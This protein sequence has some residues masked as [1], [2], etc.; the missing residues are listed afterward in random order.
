MDDLILKSF[1][2]ELT[3]DEQKV[4]N[5]FLETEKGKSEFEKFLQIR[6]I[7]NENRLHFLDGFSEKVMTKVSV[8]DT[9]IIQYDFASALYK[10]FK[11][12]AIIGAAAIAILLA[13]IYYFHGN[14]GIETITGLAGFSSDQI[15][16]L[17]LYQ[18]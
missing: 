7:L 5:Q 1:D 8:L 18:Y 13:G 6:E 10:I 15:A 4:L 9:Q 16:S 17:I 12:V 14:I 3:V 2:T 11:K